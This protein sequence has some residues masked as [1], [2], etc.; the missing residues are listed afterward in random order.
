LRFSDPA[1]TGAIAGAG[2]SQLVDGIVGASDLMLTNEVVEQIR[3]LAERAGYGVV[4]QAGY[5][6]V[7]PRVSGV[8]D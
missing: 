1:V 4:A 2:S 6:A 7:D 5:S 3:A 8:S